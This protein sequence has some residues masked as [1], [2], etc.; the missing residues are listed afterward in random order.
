[1]EL[2]LTIPIQRFLHLPPPDYGVEPDRR[3]CWDLHVINLRGRNSLLAVHCYS[4]YTFVCYNLS[5]LEWANLP[6]AFET[7]L[8]ESLANVSLPDK[9]IEDYFRR[10]GTLA[11]TRTHGRREVAF[12][13]RAW[14]DILAVD[15]CLDP[16]RQGQPLLDHTVNTKPSRCVGF[17]G[18]GAAI[19]RLPLGL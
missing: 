1:M 10:A 2:G 6:A 16:D 18:L 19:D 4:R 8:W 17:D 5:P 9:I 11:F 13:N 14:E 3:Y 15:L 12:F 7:G